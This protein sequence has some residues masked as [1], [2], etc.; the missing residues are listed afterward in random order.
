MLD[1]NRMTER[2][3]K[4]HRDIPEDFRL[5]SYRYP[6]PESSIAQHPAKQRDGSGLLV[7]D[8]SSKQALATRFVD[9]AEHLPKNALLVANNSRVLPARIFGNKPSGGRVE[10][11]L[12]TPIGLVSPVA[13]GDTL[14]AEANGLLRASK[15]LKPGNRVL[16]A[17]SLSLTVLERGEFGRCRVELAWQGDLETIFTRHGHM[18][19][20]PYIH[21]PDSEKDA[22]RYQTTYA[23]TDKIGSVAAPTAGLHFTDQVRTDL[24]A[25]GFGWTEVTLYVGYGTFSPVRAPDIR[26]HRMH[27]EYVEVS[28][29]T[30]TAVARAKAE[31]R[32]VVAVG[33]TSVRALEGM[34]R[35]TG[36]ISE[37]AGLTDLY[38]YPGSKFHVVDHLLTNFHLPES[39]LLIMISALAGRKTVLAAYGRA[40][41]QGFRFFSYGDA[42]LIV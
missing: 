41:D 40:L 16:F 6:L 30:A 22:A 19:L 9:L 8:R 33:T 39:S 31:G 36:K 18:P 2:A 25:R 5:E 35:A 14:R 20:P 13:S 23:R 28:R 37:F 1:G 7:L 15:G 17:D 3:G 12:L 29:E 42:M 11:L 21:R 38:L 10:F 26:D 24:A 4:N 34:Y 27:E 32:P